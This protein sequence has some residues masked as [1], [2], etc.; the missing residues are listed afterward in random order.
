MVTSCKKCDR[1]IT[2]KD[3]SLICDVCKEIFHTTCTKLSR[4]E[5]QCIQNRSNRCIKFHCESCENVNTVLLIRDLTEQLLALRKELNEV[6]TKLSNS[7]DANEVTEN[8]E[9][10]ITEIFERQ[11]HANNIIL[12]NLE[13]SLEPEYETKKMQDK[14]KIED[15]VEDIIGLKLPLKAF[16]LGARKND[17][18]RPI[19]IILPSHA[20]AINVLKNKRNLKDGLKVSSDSTP[21]QREYYHKIRA[22]LNA[23]TNNGEK[24]LIIRYKNGLP[25]IAQK[26]IN[27]SKN[28]RN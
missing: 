12:Y 26:V 17:K 18:P 10:I 6:K 11:K 4:S 15:I 14:N 23:R 27:D 3:K 1:D 16:R 7:N 9:K 25:R 19:K 13:E 22:E 2:D 8:S 5:V 20:D 21:M 24:D 28:Y